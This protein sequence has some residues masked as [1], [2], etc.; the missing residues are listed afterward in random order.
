MREITPGISDS[1][2]SKNLYQMNEKVN[3]TFSI[4]E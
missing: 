3:E 4:G 2:I 1:D